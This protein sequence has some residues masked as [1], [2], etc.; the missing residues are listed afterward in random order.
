MKRSS[1]RKLF[2]FCFVFVLC[3]LVVNKGETFLSLMKYRYQSSDF[4]SI[5][6]ISEISNTKKNS[7]IYL[8]RETCPTC[9]EFVSQVKK[10]NSSDRQKIYYI[11]TKK[12]SNNP[13]FKKFIKKEKIS[14]VPTLI[15]IKRNKI[16]KIYSYPDLNKNKLK[17]ILKGDIYL[18]N[19]SLR[20]CQF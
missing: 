2:I 14:T 17:S 12:Q 15:Y 5:T 16:I 9:R 4:I 7:I 1:R 8:G 20:K 19:Q 13:Q 10:V 18:W 11:D 6:S 3:F